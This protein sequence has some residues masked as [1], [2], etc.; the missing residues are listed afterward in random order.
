MK[1]GQWQ[2]TAVQ[3]RCVHRWNNFPCI[4]SL[5]DTDNSTIYPSIYTLYGGKTTKN[6]VIVNDAGFLFG[7]VLNSTNFLLSLLLQVAASQLCRERTFEKKW[8]FILSSFILYWKTI[9]GTVVNRTRHFINGK[10]FKI[11]SIVPSISLFSMG[12]Y[13]LVLYQKPVINVLILSCIVSKRYQWV[14][15]IL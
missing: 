13:Y 11:T 2:Y 12:L 4:I 3:K 14:N 7:K 5:I 15:I 1:D 9:K 6:V 8:I 10:S